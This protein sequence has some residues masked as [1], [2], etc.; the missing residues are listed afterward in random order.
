[1]SPDKFKIGDIK[2]EDGGKNLIDQAPGPQKKAKG[3]SGRP[4]KKEV[5][6]LTENLTIYF[7]KSEMEKL[8]N[9]SK[10]N[11]DVPLAKL[12]RGLLK[13]QGII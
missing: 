9:L 5:D 3:K 13:K 11:F 2:K 10:E 6:K 12:V 1:M 8:I 4:S 7:K